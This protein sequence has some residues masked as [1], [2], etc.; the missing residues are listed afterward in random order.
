MQLH[1]EQEKPK[2]EIKAYLNREYDAHPPDNVRLHLVPRGV[3]RIVDGIGPD[4]DS[5]NAIIIQA[6]TGFGK[7]HWILHEV[8]P[9]VVQ[10]GGKMLLVSNR[11]AVS[12]QQK[13]KVMKIV[14]PSEIS[15]LTSEGVLKKTDFG[16][17]KIMT[18]QALDL[19]LATAQGKEYAKEVS[20]LVID[21]VHYFTADVAFSPNAARLLKTIPQ[22]FNN[23]TR[24]YMTA[25][26]DDV[27]RPIAEAEADVKRPI[28]ERIGVRY[29]PLMLGQSPVVNVYQFT[30]DKYEQLPVR[31]VREDNTLY[32]EIKASNEKWLVFVSSKAQGEL[33]NEEIGNDATFISADSKGSEEWNRLLAEERSSHRVLVTTSVLD[34][35]VNIHDD[36]LKHVVIPFEDQ[37]AFMQAL[38]R[39]RFDGRPNFTLYIKAIDKKRLDVLIG[40]NQRLLL[41]ANEIQINRGYNRYVDR[42]RQEGDRTKDSLL[43]LDY[44]GR[45]NFN[46]LLY[47]K[48]LR[49][50]SYYKQLETAIEQYGDSAFPRL[51]HQWLGQPDAYDDQNWMGHDVAKEGMQA[52]LAF[53]SEYNGRL[54]STESEQKIFSI[55]FHRYYKIV[56]G[57]RRVDNRGDGY[58]K[59][60][61]LNNCLKK[62]GINGK[63]KSRGKD[64]GWI[65]T[66]TEDKSEKTSEQVR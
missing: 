50:E 30:S 12:Y 45:Y 63:V 20:V 39:K 43:Y 62:L 17:V 64:S 48:L 33:I 3:T 46:D 49:Q 47:H 65:F 4:L 8:L 52:L 35:G 56:T 7:T 44:V 26:L 25:T 34:C 38:G 61:A 24:I 21:E 53:L 16:P 59:A 11:V 27:L 22:S 13:L 28:M 58:K 37:V 29:S 60:S 10:A 1:F 18:L 19:F 66:M 14:N 42:F 32:R 57:D 9:R 5:F 2:A 40:R 15:C 55:T 54:L 23:A 51:V 36:D 41:L 6:P 31:Y